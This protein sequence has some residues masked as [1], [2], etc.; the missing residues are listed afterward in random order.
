MRTLRRI[1]DI[2]GLVIMKTKSATFDVCIRPAVA[3]YDILD[4]SKLDQLID[5]GREAATRALPTIRRRM[6]EAAERSLGPGV[7]AG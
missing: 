2:E 7:R 4:F 5:V 6:S 1:I 3:G